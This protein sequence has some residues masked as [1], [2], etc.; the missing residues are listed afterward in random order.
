MKQDKHS[1]DY[2]QGEFP[3]MHIRKGSTSRVVVGRLIRLCPGKHHAWYESDVGPVRKP[4][5]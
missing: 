4:I 5:Q 1:I 3:Q 2:L